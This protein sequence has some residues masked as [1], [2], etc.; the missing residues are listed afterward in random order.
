M[1]SEGVNICHRLHSLLY[2]VV[3]GLVE[4]GPLVGG[5]PELRVVGEADGRP[6]PVHVPVDADVVGLVPLVQRP[7]HALDHVVQD[8]P[9]GGVADEQQLQKSWKCRKKCHGNTERN[10]MKV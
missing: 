5:Q 4:D 3:E 1:G 8:A 10:V 6:A 9:V 7:V 2:E